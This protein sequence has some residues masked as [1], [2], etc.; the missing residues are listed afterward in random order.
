MTDIF[1]R[2][3]LFTDSLEPAGWQKPAIRRALILSNQAW[4][5]D[6]YDDKTTKV[7]TRL[8]NETP[9]SRLA[10]QRQ[11]T[12]LAAWVVRNKLQ[13]RG[14]RILDILIVLLFLPF[15]VPVM[16]V[17]ALAIRLDSPG[18]VIFRQKRVGKWGQE[19]NCYKF[20]S[21]Y[22]DAEAHKQELMDQNEADEIVFKIRN[23]PR[24]TR[25][26][27]IIRKLSIDETPQILNVLKGE[28]SFVGP[29]PPVPCEVEYYEY[30]H[31]YRLDAMPGITGLQ[32]ISGRSDMTFKR[33]VELDLLYIQEQSLLKDLEIILKTIPAV[34]LRKGAY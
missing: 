15:F 18:G 32:Q 19:F 21:M 25:V 30:D 22:A 10:L 17:T 31:F 24:V 29:R 3:N 4:P 14:K 20:R 28:M 6:R 34:I 16:L 9:S 1:Q 27:R 11:R 5:A 23:D 2:E 26:G 8:L 33:W 7:L 13:A 12:R